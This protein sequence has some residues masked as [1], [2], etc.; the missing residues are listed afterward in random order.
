ME[1]APSQVPIDLQSHE[2]EE[3]K[4]PMRVGAQSP[5]EGDSLV[6]K[7]RAAQRS[8]PIRRAADR[9]ADERLQYIIDTFSRAAADALDE[10]STYR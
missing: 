3:T 1:R 7:R 10:S 5:G 6:N 4:L 9:D 8:S 2:G